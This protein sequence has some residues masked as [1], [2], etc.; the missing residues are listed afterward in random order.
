MLDMGAVVLCHLGLRVAH[1]Y[2]LMATWAFA[3]VPA[4][5]ARTAS[6]ITATAGL[7][8]KEVLLVQLL[9]SAS[10]CTISPI[11][12]RLRWRCSFI[13]TLTVFP[14]LLAA[15]SGAFLLGVRALEGCTKSHSMSPIVFV[16]RSSNANCNCPHSCSSVVAWSTKSSPELL[17][18]RI[19]QVERCHRRGHCCG[20]IWYAEKAAEIHQGACAPTQGIHHRD[21]KHGEHPADGHTSSHCIRTHTGNTA[22]IEPQTGCE[23]KFVQRRAGPPPKTRVNTDRATQ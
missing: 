10:P 15:V 18:V 19:H 2:F 16:C 12:C 21:D 4:R 23:R 11:I 9:S 14:F 7:T 3:V 13:L 22:G 6:L 17:Q 5:A 8:V 20:V 1:V